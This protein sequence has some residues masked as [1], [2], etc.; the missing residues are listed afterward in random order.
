M[1]RQSSL[2]QKRFTRLRDEGQARDDGNAVIALLAEFGD[3]VITHVPQRCGGKLALRAL[4]FLQAQH[5]GLPV[6]EKPGDETDAQT[7]PS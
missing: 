1:W 6:F 4:R 3:V 2:P 7:A 5:V